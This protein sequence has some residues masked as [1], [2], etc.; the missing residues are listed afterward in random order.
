MCEKYF[1]T[2]NR[3]FLHCSNNI[4]LLS[5]WYFFTV[6]SIFLFCASSSTAYCSSSA[7]LWSCILQS[8]GY[9]AVQVDCHAKL[10]FHLFLHKFISIHLYSSCPVQAV[11]LH[12]AFWG[13]I[14]Q[15]SSDWALQVEEINE[16]CKWIASAPSY[17]LQQ[18]K[19]KYKNIDRTENAECC[20]CRI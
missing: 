16:L 20:P 15:S 13:Q 1:L 2:V 11:F 7:L 10:C 17:S 8:S 6:Q 5:R 18:N 4:S 9:R 14:L 3:I 12:C 19:Y